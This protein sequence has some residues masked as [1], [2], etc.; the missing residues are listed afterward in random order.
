MQAGKL[1]VFQLTVTDD[2]GATGSG[3]VRIMTVT[4]TGITGVKNPE[5][6]IYPNPFTDRIHIECANTGNLERVVLTSVTGQ[7]VWEERVNGSGPIVLSLSRLEK[8]YYILTLFSDKEVI[9][10]KV[11]KR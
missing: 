5:V 3:N 6:T 4:G 11:L 1:Y 10:R 9:S 7:V 8:G 2:K